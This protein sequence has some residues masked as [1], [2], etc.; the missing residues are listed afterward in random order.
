[1]HSYFN[2]SVSPNLLYFDWPNVELY[3]L[4]SQ[5]KTKYESVIIS[6]KDIRRILIGYSEEHCSVYLI[7]N[8]SEIW[9]KE[10]WY[11]LGG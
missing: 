10:Q 7:M 8:Q 3:E 6:Y 2:P 4:N 1:M 11:S 5:W 9:Y